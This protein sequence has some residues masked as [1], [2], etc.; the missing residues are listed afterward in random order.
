MELWDLYDIND[1]LTGEIWERIPGNFKKIP[2]GR[3][4]MVC[5][6]LVKHTDGTYLLT[7][8]DLNKDVYPGYWEAT[9]G[10]SALKGESPL[11]CAKRELFE[12]T[13][14]KSDDFTLISHT[15]RENSHSMF[16]SY[17]AVTDCDKDSIVLQEGETIDYKWVDEKGL[18]E[19]A[20]SEN[21]IKSHN[22]RYEDFF[23]KLRKK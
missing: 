20:D 9:A 14:I 2:E 16:Y 12:E 6:I 11:E 5:D 15:R 18:L 7:Q 22:L 23:E 3:F 17:L 1:N 19:Y 21:A 8:R 10:G 13:G 4:H